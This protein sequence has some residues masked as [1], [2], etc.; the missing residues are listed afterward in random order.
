MRG[1]KSEKRTQ[2]LMKRNRSRGI[3]EIGELECQNAEEE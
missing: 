2:P 1:T 3:R